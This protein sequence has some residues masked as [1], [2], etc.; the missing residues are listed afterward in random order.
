[1]PRDSKTEDG[2]ITSDRLKRPSPK[3]DSNEVSD[4]LTWL[5]GDLAQKLHRMNLRE[6]A[7]VARYLDLLGTQGIP[8]SV[9]KG[10]PEE[11]LD[12]GLRQ[13]SSADTQERRCVQRFAQSIWTTLF[14]FGR[15]D[16]SSEPETRRF[17]IKHKGFWRNDLLFSKAMKFLEEFELPSDMPKARPP[18]LVSRHLGPHGTSKRRL[19]NDLS[20]RIAAANCILRRAGQRGVRDRIAEQLNL[21][22]SK[23]PEAG[24]GPEEVGER[25]KTYGRLA[26]RH[27]DD[28]LIDKWITL[29]RADKFAKIS[30]VARVANKAQTGEH[31]P[32]R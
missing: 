3:L 32:K 9:S 14:Q 21:S 19:E 26:K 24:W 29:Y 20:E 13:R 6:A 17:L 4:F 12:Y 10:S 18:S 23:K 1:M 25:V 8:R 28:F 27:P 22:T 30:S 15:I 2:W 16:A 31:P 7:S 11:V 5:F